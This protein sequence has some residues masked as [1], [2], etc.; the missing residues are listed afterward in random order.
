M[1]ETDNAAEGAPENAIPAAPMVVNAQYVKDLSFENPNAP[2][3]LSQM[4]SAPAIGVN[5]DVTT[6]SLGNNVHE[7]VL[8]VQAEA[9]YEDKTLFLVEL[10]YGGV[11]TLGQVPDEA[12]QPL[13]LIEAPRMMFPF[14]RA[15]VAE[16]T[17]DGGFPPLL[18]NPIDFTDLYRRRLAE[19]AGEGREGGEKADA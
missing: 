14:A 12:V 2:M 7:T 13:L 6:R 11:F 9:R 15:I 19:E 17:R 10:T 1:S 8:A 16:C 3:S 4:Q 18:I 5:V